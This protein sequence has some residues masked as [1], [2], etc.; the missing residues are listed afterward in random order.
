MLC[1]NDIYSNAVVSRFQI[2]VTVAYWGLQSTLGKVIFN[3]SILCTSL[4]YQIIQILRIL[5][6]F[7]LPIQN[8]VY[9][10]LKLHMSMNISVSSE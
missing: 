5:L 1:N 3:S 2:G 10:T 7:V 6:S 9:L 4:S 8:F